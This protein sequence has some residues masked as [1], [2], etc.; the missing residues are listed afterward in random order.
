M[1]EGPGTA[2]YPVLTG[3]YSA[4]QARWQ[5]KPIAV[6]TPLARPVPLFHK[7]DEALGQTGPQWAPL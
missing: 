5:S 2:S 1:D 6:G 4:E 7:L 3:D